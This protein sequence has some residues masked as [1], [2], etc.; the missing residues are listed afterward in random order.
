MLVL[1]SIPF[2]AK[3]GWVTESIPM[4]KKQAEA[5]L[6]VR[7]RNNEGQNRRRYRLVKAK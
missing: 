2:S 4:Y 7:L 5:L 6:K 1:E 3:T